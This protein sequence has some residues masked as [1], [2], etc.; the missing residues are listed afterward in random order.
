MKNNMSVLM[1]SAL[2]GLA[3]TAPAFAQGPGGG[4]PPPG[5]GGGGQRRPFAFG[6]VSAVDAT[7]GTLTIT[8]QNGDS[9]TVKVG[10]DAQIV[11]QQTVKVSDLKVGDQIAV[12]GVPTGLTASS[13]TAGQPPA[14][15]PGAGGF[16]GPRGG[17]NG[18]GGN[19][20]GGGGNTANTASQGFA[21]A[22]GT[23]KTLPTATDAHLSIALGADAVL[24]VKMADGAKVTKYATVALGDIKTGDK[25]VARGDTADD[26]TLTATTVGVNLQMGGPGGGGFGGF[27]GGGF[28]GGG[29]G[30][31]GFGGRR[32]GGRRGGGGGFGGP[33]PPGQGA[34]PPPGGDGGA[35]PPPG[36]DGGPPPQ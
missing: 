13:L 24:F 35:P 12:Q 2:I 36:G 21:T 8:T 29:F 25:I 31:G 9:Q 3:L 20:G 10:T 19:G 16:G 6:T 14:G 22:S 7:G 32:G 4:P 11:T 5:Q 15:L 23:I 30:G 17:G 34:P 1:A 26:G 28:G 27:G 33:P 18:G